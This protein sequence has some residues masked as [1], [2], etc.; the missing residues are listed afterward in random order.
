M[1]E[2]FVSFLKQSV[3]KE[4]KT[5]KK[6]HFIKQKRKKKGGESLWFSLMIHACDIV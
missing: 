4:N 1:G 6:K 3:T 2:F 5:K